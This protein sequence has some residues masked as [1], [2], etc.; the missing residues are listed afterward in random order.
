MHAHPPSQS[1]IDPTILPIH[2]H[3]SLP[4]PRTL[5]YTYPHQAHT[6]PPT[7]HVHPPPSTLTLPPS[8][9]IHQQANSHRTKHPHRPPSTL[10]L[11]LSTVIPTKQR[12]T[13]LSTLN[14]SPITRETNTKGK[15]RGEHCQ[16][17]RCCNEVEGHSVLL[18][19]G[20]QCGEVLMELG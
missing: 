16:E 6:H 20:M 8:T 9:L 17:P 10:T 4:P 19:V 5:T 18:K 12:H 1:S 15:L 14:N 7:K 2:T 11:P 13:V 3:M